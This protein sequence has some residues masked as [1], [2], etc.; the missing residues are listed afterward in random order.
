MTPINM[1]SVK[2][3][4]IH[5]IGHDAA[6]NTLAIRFKSRGEPAVLYHYSNVSADDFTAFKDAESV[7]S[8]FY[9]HIKADTERFPFQ[10]INEKKDDE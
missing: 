5:S 8:H 2:S 3:S 7:G 10:R 4:Q 1:T 9:K 6:T